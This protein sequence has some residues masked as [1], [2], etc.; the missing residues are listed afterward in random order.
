MTPFVLYVKGRNDKGQQNNLS[1]TS[2]Q[3]FS[4]EFSNIYRLIIPL[5]I[6][7]RQLDLVLF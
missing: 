7:N 5:M 4:R 6:S 1:H 2:T 3:T